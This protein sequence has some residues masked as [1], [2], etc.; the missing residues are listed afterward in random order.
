MTRELIR[1]Q[2]AKLFLLISRLSKAVLQLDEVTGMQEYASSYETLFRWYTG[3]NIVANNGTS[4]G[5]VVMHAHVHIV[6]RRRS[7]SLPQHLFRS[8][9]QLRSRDADPI[10]QKL[11]SALDT[12]ILPSSTPFVPQ[13][14]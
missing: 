9:P 14:S 1:Y 3:S 5:Q 2:G 10:L 7:D 4:A 12:S 6:P 13:S 11:K 8:G